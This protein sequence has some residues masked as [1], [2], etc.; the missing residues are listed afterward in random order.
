MKQHYL[1]YIAALLGTQTAMAQNQVNL[2]LTD[3]NTAQYETDA[4]KSIDFNGANVLVNPL[5]GTS[6]SYNGTVSSISFQK[7]S[8]GS[9]V[10]N[11]AKG[12]LET[13][14]AEWQPLAG[15]TDYRVY[16]KGGAYSDYTRIDQSLVRTYPS[17]VRADVVGLK[18]GTYTLKVVPVINGS[19]STAKATETSTLTVTNYQRAGFAH[20]GYQGV[21]AYNDDGTL[22]TGAV[23][24]YVSAA[25]AKTVTAQLSSG[26]FT[27]IQAILSAYEKGNVT[28]PL[29]VRIIGTI[30]AGDVDSFGSSAEGLQIK[31]RKA[32]SE[33]NITIEGIGEDATIKGFGFLVRNSKSVEFRNI[34]IM[35]QMDDGI[36]LDTD[37]SNIWIHHVDVFYGKSG[38]GDH[39]KGD[40]SI[41][42]KSDS[43]FITIDHCHFWDTG[44]SSMAG[45]TSESGPNYITYHHNWF[46]HSDSRHAR[47]RTMSVHLWNNYYDGVAKYGIGATTGSSIFAEN[48]YF[49]HTHNPLL[50][51]LQGTDAK[52]TGTFSGESGGI[53]KAYGNTYAETGNSTYYTP[54]TWAQNN[55]SFDCYEA[56]DRNEQIPAS[57][58]TL[59]GGSSYNNFDTNASLMYT[60]T[61]D[62]TADVP[63]AVTGVYGAGRL[64]HG[65]LQYTF[66]NTTDDTADAVNTALAALIDG[67]TGYT[68]TTGT[69]DPTTP[70]DPTDPTTD[71]TDPT[72]TTDPGISGSV[73]CSFD[74]KG[75]PSSSMF[76]VVGNGSN[77]KGTATYNGTTYNTCLKLEST[78]SIKF[79][80]ADDMT[81]T[82]VFASTETASFKLNGNK[83][84]STANMYTIDLEAGSY[85]ITKADSRNLFL[86]V[87]AAK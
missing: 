9:V 39:A 26:S 21:G 36:S 27:G 8:A 52:G 15:A 77:S 16:I 28:T 56:S 55:T 51:S 10:I 11:E 60:Y 73:L 23:V 2:K 12:W 54:I 24:V 1:L 74:A 87:L 71:P 19:E 85:E 37:N 75:V 17:Y 49:R 67:Y 70:T 3:G 42:V 33:L 41:D 31:G 84:T 6:T 86:I 64:N 7:V 47:V 82:L 29:A 80:L 83:L 43:K 57:V 46:D 72:E 81:M 40:G 44:K 20:K 32:D 5:T 79:T 76:T 35:R 78:T 61:P 14:Y 38:S 58:V 34:G 4:L 25:T 66:N 30:K 13:A 69:T 63:T 18:A 59:S 22:K 65:D 62:A 45:M 53:I 50:I 68:P 48:N